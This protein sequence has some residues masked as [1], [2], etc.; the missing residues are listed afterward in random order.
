M[1][2]RSGSWHLW[3]L[4]V[5]TAI[6]ALLGACSSDS[7][8]TSASSASSG[9]FGNLESLYADIVPKSLTYSSTSLMMPELMGGAAARINPGDPCLGYSLF[10]CQPIMLRMYIEQAKSAFYM[11]MT[12]LLRSKTLI[13]EQDDNSSG[14]VVSPDGYNVLYRKTNNENFEMILK[15]GSTAVMYFRVQYGS[16]YLLRMSSAMGGNGNS[17]SQIS[18]DG[19]NNWTVSIMRTGLTCS[20]NNGRTPRSIKVWMNKKDDVWFGA[21]H[22]FSPVWAPVPGAAPDCAAF[23][24]TPPYDN[25]RG[26]HFVTRFAGN[27]SVA[28]AEVAIMK[29]EVA[30]INDSTM[31]AWALWLFPVN[32]SSGAAMPSVKNPF[33]VR[34]SDINNALWVNN[35]SSYDGRIAGF[36]LVAAGLTAPSDFINAAISFPSSY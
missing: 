25:A 11:V 12:V 32:Y 34:A 4:G 9:T 21:A 7:G 3:S 13:T 2:K 35:C 8:Y 24:A 23:D 36:S 33:C 16:R 31:D 18:Y 22:V 19:R 29:N 17:E 27:D 28:K 15:S 26:A 14:T 1:M 30:A 6:M 20:D 10:E 5:L